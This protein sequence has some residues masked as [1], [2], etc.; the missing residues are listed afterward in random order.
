MIYRAPARTRTRRLPGLLGA[1]LLVV[2]AAL[3][4][5]LGFPLLAPSSPTAA[6]PVVTLRTEP[7]GAPSAADGAAP[8]GTTVFATQIP[9]VVNLDPALLRALRQA[10]TKAADDGVEF[11]V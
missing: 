4:T 2:I 3:A 9:A 11:F 5:A 7:R 6:S 10:A 1:G 8:G